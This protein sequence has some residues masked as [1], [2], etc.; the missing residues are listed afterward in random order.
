MKNYN[1]PSGQEINEGF[2]ITFE[3]F[4]YVSLIVFL[5]VHV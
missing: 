2:A 3:I 4:E 5:F 1:W